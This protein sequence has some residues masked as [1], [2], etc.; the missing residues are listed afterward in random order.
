[1]LL[2]ACG[3]VASL[4]LA[5]ATS[6]QAEI[7]IRSALGAS[8][9]RL[10]RQLLTESMTLAGAGGALGFLLALALVR[11]I[12]AVGAGL[13]PRLAEVTVSPEVAAF[14]IV[15]ALATGLLFGLA[16]ALHAARSDLA[17][18]FAGI[19]KGSSGKRSVRLRDGLVVAQVAL[20][21][22]LL[23]GAGLLMRT[24]WELNHV[25][26]GFDADHVLTA[27][28]GLP[29]QR[30]ADRESQVR[31]WTGVLDG[32]RAAPGVVS[33]SA[34]T[35][36]PM[37]GGGDTYFWRADK[38]PATPKDR[39]NAL[40][41]IVADDYFETMHIGMT[42]GR[43][44]GAPERN[45][46]GNAIILNKRLAGQLFTA[47]E[48]PIGKHLVVDF[49]TQFDGEIVGV[50]DDVRSNGP[51]S[52]A[53]PTLYFPVRQPG[54]FGAS[55]FTVVVRTKGDPSLASSAIRTTLAA[56]DRDIPLMR[57]QTMDNVVAMTTSDTRLA[58]QMLGGFAFLALALAVVGLYGVL[59]YAV[60][61]RAKELGI[62]VAFGASRAQVFSMV[63]RRGM[64]I[65]GVGMAIGI[66]G[67][68]GATRLMNGML[69]QVGRTDPTVF[70]IVAATLAMAGFVACVVPARAATRVDP[71]AVLR[72]E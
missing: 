65:V 35:M 17:A 37:A 20:S 40:I 47:D 21:L 39:R 69:F 53:P 48:N 67:A 38:P 3:N 68:F 2:I 9:M 24:L 64:A 60:S 54:G 14:T 4:L 62:R 11:G 6:R 58:A 31:V 36:L 12:R 61:Q 27:Q 44:F 26:P 42:S 52:N 10:I 7:G 25:K 41:S 51:A 66:A 30:Y 71:V 70:V 15:V 46:S 45:P 34:T 72:G 19:G 56:I 50:S 22:M 5:R 1:V 49:G 32:V 63:L 33:A 59:T 43:A 18:T 16:P 13:V 28:I 29:E 55:Y 23:V 8:R 57:V